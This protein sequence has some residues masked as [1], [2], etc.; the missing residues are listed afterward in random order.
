M[1]AARRRQGLAPRRHRV[2]GAAALTVTLV[3]SIAAASVADDTT[4]P[5][6]EQV[7][8][9]QAAAGAK[10]DEVGR[11]QAELALAN[12]ELRQSAVAAG[13]AAEAFNGARWHL[14][15]ARV[16]VR[17]ADA[18]ATAAEADAAARRQV[19]ADT[20][21][22]GYQSGP[23]MQGVSTLLEAQGVDQFTQDAATFSNA[24]A[25]MDDQYDAYQAS[26]TLA[27]V[28][29][30]QAADARA[31]A[32]RAA[33]EA[34]AARDAARAAEAAALAKAQQVGQ[35]KDQLLG[36]LAQL[37]GISKDLA[38]RRQAALEAAAAQAAADA[39]AD[40]DPPADAGDGARTGAASRRPPRHPTPVTAAPTRRL[41]RTRHPTRALTPS[42]PPDPAPPPPAS[43][44]SA[45]IAFAEAQLG[46]PYK[47]GAAGPNAWDCSGLTMMA[48][49]SGGRSLPH[50]SVAQYQQSTP[51]SSA[52]LRPGDLVFWG[53]S[54][55]S[56]SI[57]H[58]ALYVGDGMIIHAPRT[59]R[60][61]SRESM[62][63]WIAPNFFA[64]P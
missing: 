25:A 56:S 42:R 55:R 7:D 26:A 59:G 48:W 16:A 37:Q 18:A 38:E 8:A 43:G 50:Y 32:S 44:A 61:V 15:Q 9:A 52:D 29:T 24:E 31:E 33:D 27:T 34:R 45:A 28:A 62:Y 53:S 4:T 14:R 21:V 12:E 47:W 17:R 57:Y 60:D 39:A 19:I 54:S 5:S 40:Q 20:L 6:Q 36:E 1:R 3:L 23:T 11:V 30:Q 35:R 58:V 46:E 49:R 2:W 41:A 51:I 63:Y 64:R 13:Q 22:N 10:A